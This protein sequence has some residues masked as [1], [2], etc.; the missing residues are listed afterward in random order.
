LSRSLSVFSHN[1]QNTSLDV[2]LLIFSHI[3]EFFTESS[4]DESIACS[5][6]SNEGS[7][8]TRITEDGNESE[9]ETQ[10]PLFKEE[11][12]EVSGDESVDSEESVEVGVLNQELWQFLQLDLMQELVVEVGWTDFSGHFFEIFF[13]TV[14]TTCT[15]W[16][17][18]G[19]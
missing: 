11:W 6:V 17:L 8:D 9:R 18:A 1:L 3:V 16:R 2:I 19:P 4:V 7:D 15:W 14:F 10:S 12:C 13:R 5:I